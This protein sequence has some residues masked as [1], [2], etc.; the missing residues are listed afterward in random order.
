MH[1]EH[2]GQNA[3]LTELRARLND[4]LA[5]SRMEK[6]DLQARSGLGRTTVW[7]A[8]QP[9]EQAPS[10]K[11]V[12]ALARALRLPVKELLELQ[13][14]AVEDTGVRSA[15]G[16]PIDEWDPHHLEVHPAGP[17]DAA[18]GPRG[19]GARTL[20][21]YVRREHDRV[22]AGLVEDALAGRSRAVVLVGS[23]ST[24]KTRACWEAVQPLE[25]QGWRLWHPF[26]PTRA[27][28]ALDGLSWVAPRTV[29]W[30][31]EARR[32]RL[33]RVLLRAAPGD[34]LGTN[35]P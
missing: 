13:R 33:P 20:P 32:R 29:V 17:D 15:P 11:T 4:G 14:R 7:E 18:S 28:D 6:R 12:A 5:R 9:G 30:L 16:R 25:A 23:S 34:H 1:D 35:A 27:Q 31:N 2:D 10:A 21:G 22:L 8:M 26:Y 24:G 19:S 3:A